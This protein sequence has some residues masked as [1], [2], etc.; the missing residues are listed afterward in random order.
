MYIDVLYIHYHIYIVSNRLS[1]CKDVSCFHR[2]IIGIRYGNRVNINYYWYIS[3]EYDCNIVTWS[4]PMFRFFFMII[5]IKFSIN[6]YLVGI[7]IIHHY[8]FSLWQEKKKWK[9][10]KRRKNKIKKTEKDEWSMQL[11]TW[12]FCFF[13]F[14]FPFV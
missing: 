3:D 9:E 2:L 8:W 7:L 12:I 6:I 1:F 10:K 14:F 5:E 11:F 13:F 4:I